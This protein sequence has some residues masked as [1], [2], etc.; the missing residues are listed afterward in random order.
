MA[1]ATLT[2]TPDMTMEAILAVAPSA[3]R[4]LFQRFHVGGCS[5]CGFQPSDTLAQVAKDHNLLDVKDVIQTILRAETMDRERQVSPDDLRSWRGRGEAFRFI[6]VRL[7]DER[8]AAPLAAG[9][10]AEPLDY[11]HSDSYMSLPKDTRI[12]FGCADGGR[13]L[14]VA[15]YF[16]GHGFGAV[17]ALRGGFSG[18]SAD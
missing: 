10:D 1:D 12:V 2:I 5:A 11:D 13:S 14:D 7:P 17:Y 6:D 9:V 4:A 8:S 3:Q 16:L 18:W 15:S